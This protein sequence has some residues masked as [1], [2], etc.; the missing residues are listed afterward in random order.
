MGREANA[1]SNELKL[2]LLR[3]NYN[4]ALSRLHF[5]AL[6][7][8]SLIGKAGFRPDQL[9][10][11]RGYSTGGQWTDGGSNGGASSRRRP[12][13]PRAAG[14][15]VAGGRT[16]RPS[17]NVVRVAGRTF[18][19]TPT[20]SA[21]LVAA[22]LNASRAISRA[23]NVDPTYKPPAGLYENVSGL[24]QH[25][26]GQARHAQA[27]VFRTNGPGIGHNQ[28]PSLESTPREA[29]ATYR[30]ILSLPAIP[31]GPQPSKSFGTVSFA[32][33]G[34]ELYF[35]VNSE[36]AAYTNVDSRAAAAMRET[37]IQSNPET[38]ARAN[39]GWR[40]NDALYHAEA[41]ILFRMAA[42]NGGTLRGRDI[43][44]T[45]DRP[46]C[47]SCQVIIPLVAQRLGIRNLTIRELGGRVWTSRGNMLVRER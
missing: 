29:I 35:G 44:M 34:K 9:R 32:R 12:V 38:M 47:G 43:E 10:V 37:L 23:R 3:S 7:L 25:I 17:S 14:V 11:P 24:I 20:Q 22:R 2:N 5:A 42:L 41:T 31:R 30:E 6:H 4:L 27:H 19:A 26:R 16:F 36:S 40:P 46:V 18:I 15:R 13:R 28:G 1:T 8:F 45:V 33:I 21:R 39:I